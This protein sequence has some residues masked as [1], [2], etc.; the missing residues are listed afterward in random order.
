M[1]TLNKNLDLFDSCVFKSKKRMWL[2]IFNYVLNKPEFKLMPFK[3]KQV[4]TKKKVR[5]LVPKEFLRKL[6]EPYNLFLNNE[7]KLDDNVVAHI[8]SFDE[9]TQGLISHYKTLGM[10]EKVKE[11]EL[12]LK[13]RRLDFATKRRA[14]V[15]RVEK[16]THKRLK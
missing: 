15:S 1:K 9:I 10:Q 16:S 8:M 12:R 3:Y 7:D 11:L 14:N 13:E 4:G 6:E 2:F 5:L